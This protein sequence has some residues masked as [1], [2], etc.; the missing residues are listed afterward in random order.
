MS[1]RGDV[2]TDAFDVPGTPVSIVSYGT[3]TGHVQDTTVKRLTAT[4]IVMADGSRWYRTDLRKVGGRYG[5]GEIFPPQH[6]TARR[7]RAGQSM[8]SLGYEIDRLFRKAPAE[9]TEQGWRALH[10]EAV[11]LVASVAEKMG[12]TDEADPAR[13]E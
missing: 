10:A 8:E 13:P 1:R 7:A 2:A 3:R 4:Q 9:Y 11:A 5:D 12:W 6:P